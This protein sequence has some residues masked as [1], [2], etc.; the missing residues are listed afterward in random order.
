MEVRSGR[1]GEPG[2][3]A[4]LRHTDRGFVLEGLYAADNRRVPTDRAQIAREKLAACGV[5]LLAHAPGAREPVIAAARLLNEH[6]LA[7]PDNYVGWG[8]EVVE[9]T[10]GLQQILREAA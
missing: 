9:A 8:N 2:T 4:E 3:I 10:E 6:A 5:A 7:E 1:C